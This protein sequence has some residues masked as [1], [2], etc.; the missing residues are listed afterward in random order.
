MTWGIGLYKVQVVC[1]YGC[2]CVHACVRASV[3]ACEF[4]CECVRVWVVINNQ[5]ST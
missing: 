5:L 1:I 3:R 4:V 2:A